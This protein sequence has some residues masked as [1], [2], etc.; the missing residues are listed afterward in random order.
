MYSLSNF[1]TQDVI[2]NYEDIIDRIKKAADSVKRDYQEVRLIVVTKTFDPV[3]F[4]PL[5]D[6]GHKDFG[7]NKV[8]EAENKWLPILNDFEDI[9]LHLIGHLQ[10]NKVKKAME[11][12]YS[13]HTIDSPK[14]VGQ[15]IKNLNNQNNRC[16]EYFIELNMADEAQ[17]SGLKQDE[18]GQ[19]LDL[20]NKSSIL[21]CDGL[22]C[23]PPYDEEPS[24]YFMLLN[25]IA[26]NNGLTKLSMGMSADFEKAIQFGA[27]HVRVGSQ[28][29]GSRS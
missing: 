2:R 21:G 1:S 26:K 4:I 8:Q 13:I 24:P 7:E 5:I 20:I 15:V 10:T 22:M 3:V 11:L 14:R 23:I 16:K 6:L 27:T 19:L 9:H 29:F 28:I 25:K 12:F 17:K 18:L